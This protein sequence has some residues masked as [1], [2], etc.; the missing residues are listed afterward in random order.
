[1]RITKTEREVISSQARLCFGSGASVML[2][3]SRVDD[4]RRGGDIDLL[5]RGNWKRDESFQRKIDFL[6]AL[7]TSMG[8][9]HI[10]VVLAEPN[11]RRLI[12]AEAERTGEKL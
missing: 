3:G 10:D 8:D 5:V 2:F 11:D 12:V 4:N 1:M 9:Q 6:V 7:K